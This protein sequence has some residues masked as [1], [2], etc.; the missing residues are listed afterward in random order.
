MLNSSGFRALE[1]GWT[2]TD[3]DCSVGLGADADAEQ[4]FVAFLESSIFEWHTG[5]KRYQISSGEPIRETR[6]PGGVTP[7]GRET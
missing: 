3:H 1:K 6:T 5:M 7:N 2:V 4:T